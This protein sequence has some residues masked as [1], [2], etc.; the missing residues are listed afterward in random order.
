MSEEFLR[1]QPNGTLDEVFY[2]YTEFFEPLTSGDILSSLRSIAAGINAEN[3][4]HLAEL[5]EQNEVR[6]VV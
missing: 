6:F 4:T 3:L 1:R 2:E 5:L